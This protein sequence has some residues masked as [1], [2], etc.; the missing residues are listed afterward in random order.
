MTACW[1]RP[2]YLWRRRRNQ[3]RPP[4][5]PTTTAPGPQARAR[6]PEGNATPAA[7][8]RRLPRSHPP[9]ETASSHGPP[10]PLRLFWEAILS[11]W[12]RFDVPLGPQMAKKCASRCLETAAVR[13]SAMGSGAATG[14]PPA[15]PNR[16][17]VP[18][19][20]AAIGCQ[21]N[22]VPRAKPISA[23]SV[24]CSARRESGLSPA[25]GSSSPWQRRHGGISR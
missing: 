25:A 1:L 4:S 11:G 12:H 9:D 24:E 17:A 3:K 16:T 14:W 5:P 13:R 23:L 21:E 2:K 22:D 7:P 15:G 10:W 19:L 6:P 20:D 18:A 8:A